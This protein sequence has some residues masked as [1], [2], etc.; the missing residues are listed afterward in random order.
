MSNSTQY[1]WDEDFSKEEKIETTPNTEYILD[2]FRALS[3]EEKILT[4][5]LIRKELLF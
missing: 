1:F 5:K 3:L 4:K 2:L